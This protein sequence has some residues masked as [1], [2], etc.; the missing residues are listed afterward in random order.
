MAGP[1]RFET[2]GGE[3]HLRAMNR[4]TLLALPLLL[5]RIAAPMSASAQQ[6]PAAALTPRDSAD[7]GRIEAY[8][9]AMRTLKARFLQV[10]P[11]GAV[12]TGTAWLERPGRMRFEYD[13]PSPFLLVAGYGLV[14]FHDSALKQTSNFPLGSTPLSILLR[15]N[16]SLSGDVT[17]V[18]MVHQPGQVQVT[19]QRTATPADGTLTLIFA[20]NPLALRQWTVVDAQ[21][22]ETHVTLYDV[23]LGG[24]FDPTLFRYIDPRLL[25]PDT[26]PDPNQPGH[27]G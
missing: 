23:E 21:R 13:K 7:I 27:G 9:N 16:V 2:A 19:L 8:L 22:R 11:D 25:G 5:T 26:G 1:W 3:C 14:V 15:E 6:P 18:G 12:T 10:A 20:D 17:V 4:R 24:K